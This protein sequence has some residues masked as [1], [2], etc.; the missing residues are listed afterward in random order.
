MTVA[1]IR[2]DI[3]LAEKATQ[4]WTI[5]DIAVP[6]EFNVIRTE[7]WNIEKY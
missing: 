1:H 3:I 6:G 4:K 7:D 2:P 5:I